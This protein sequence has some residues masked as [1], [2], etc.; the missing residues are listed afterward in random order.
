MKT[1]KVFY[2][3]AK[4]YCDEAMDG[5]PESIFTIMESYATQRI[6]EL[7]TA[8]NC[9]CTEEDTTGST[10]VECCNV[11]GLPIRPE[12]WTF[13]QDDASE[14]LSEL[15]KKIEELRDFFKI[16]KYSEV[17][18]MTILVELNQILKED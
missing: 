13:I 10:T 12:S 3:E 7:K 18:K 9:T 2:K 1:A 15:R 6:T 5:V 11:C 8:S 16:Y 17:T 4:G 14:Q